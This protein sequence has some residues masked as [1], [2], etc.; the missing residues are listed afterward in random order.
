MFVDIWNEQNCTNSMNSALYE[1]GHLGLLS[2]AG[3]GSR[4]PRWLLK[5]AMSTASNTT[6]QTVWSIRIYGVFMLQKRGSRKCTTV[7]SRA[8]P[9]METGSIVPPALNTNSS[10][11]NHYC[12]AAF[13]ICEEFL[14]PARLSLWSL[15][16]TFYLLTSTEETQ[17]KGRWLYCLGF[18]VDHRLQSFTLYPTFTLKKIRVCDCKIHHSLEDYRNR[19]SMSS[20]SFPLYLKTEILPVKPPHHS[21]QPWKGT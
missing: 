6:L 10:V 14:F 21:P 5:A 12:Y 3:Y 4:C 18:Y 9:S 16:H 7:S 11:A 13:S 20:L 1:W 17:R 8:G 15:T 19:Y 2:F